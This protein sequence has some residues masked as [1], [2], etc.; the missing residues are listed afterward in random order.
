[1][2]SQ[3]IVYWSES[4]PE[5]AGRVAIMRQRPNG[6]L[7]EATPADFN[8]R[9]RV[10]EYGGG[11]YLAEGLTLY[12]VNF[13]DQRLYKFAPGTAPVAITPEPEMP[14]SLRYADGRLST[15]ERRMFWVRESHASDGLVV[16][17]LVSL[18]PDGE[19]EPVTIASGR[20]FYAAPRPSPDGRKLAWLEWDQPN[21]PWDGTELWTAEI[22]SDGR[23]ESAQQI[24]GGLEESVMQPEW[25]P[26]GALHFISDRSGWWNLYREDDAHALVPM[27]AEFG[28]PMWIFGL[29]QYAFL[30]DGRI[31]TIYSQGGVDYLALVDEVLNPV[32]LE[33]TNYKPRSL[34]YDQITD[35]LVFGAGSPHHPARVYAMELEGGS[36]ETLS[37]STDNLPRREDISH[38]VPMTFPTA[39]GHEAHAFFYAPSNSIF[40]GPEGELPPLLVVS[41]GGP[42][43]R[44]NSEFALARQYWTSRGFA[45]VDVNYRGSTGY[46]RAYRQKLNGEWGVADVEDCVHAATFLVEQGI[47]DGKRL[48]IRGGSAGGYTTLCALVFHDV[49]T[50]G[51]SYYGFADVGVFVQDTHKFEAR[52]LD[53]L[54]GPYPEALEL[55][56]ERSPINFVD[57]ISSPLILF[58]GREDKIVLPS[59][60]EIMV[61]ALEANGL[62]FAYLEFENEGHGFRDSKNITRS[63]EAELYFYSKIFGFDLGQEVEPV[64]INNL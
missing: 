13:E 24:A 55:Y 19:G 5:E 26:G 17:E 62:P 38:A 51:A 30:S 25:S 32:E 10:H 63:L 50:A 41:H 14:A 27:E 35:R 11:A 40:E 4:R 22:G 56:Q 18:S 43:S 21:M 61:E 48:I 39:G 12:A 23:L 49:F 2:V 1:M 7:E 34:H 47:V 59:Q 57:R 53:T 29:S 64:E 58:Q 42:T 8:I 28:W 60:A 46:G 6:V 36:L 52:Y 31:A 20:D 3:G 15:D 37:P 45:L 33:L 54:I 16:N 9:T 44:A